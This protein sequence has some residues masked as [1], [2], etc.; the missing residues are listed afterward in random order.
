MRERSDNV[1]V[2]N[3]LKPSITRSLEVWQIPGSRSRTL[4]KSI[5]QSKARRIARSFHAH[6]SLPLIS[7]ENCFLRGLSVTFCLE[8]FEEEN[9]TQTHKSSTKYCMKSLPFDVSSLFWGNKFDFFWSRGCNSLRIV[10][11]SVFPCNYAANAADFRVSGV[12]FLSS[13]L[14]AKM[15]SQYK[16]KGVES[17]PLCL[18]RSS[19]S[20]GGAEVPLSFFCAE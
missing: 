6:S 1:V 2:G 4:K 10:E 7:R 19:S 11:I 16:C 17:L 9:F 8:K 3:A 18:S 13:F 14:S 12:I 20:S 5:H 15:H